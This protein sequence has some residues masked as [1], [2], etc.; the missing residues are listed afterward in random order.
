MDNLEE[1]LQGN[2]EAP[3]AEAVET[4]E[5]QPEV[6]E[7]PE[8][9]TEKARARDEK[10]RF[11]PKG[12][13]PAEPEG[14]SPAPAEPQLDHAALIG[15][16]RRRQEAEDRIRALEEQ[17]KTLQQTQQPTT[18]QDQGPPDRWEDPEGYDQWLVS[19][20]AERARAEARE[21][22]QVERIAMAA[23]EMKANHPDYAEKIGVFQQMVAVNPMLADEMRRSANP[24]RYAYDVAK[25]QIEI[26]QYGGLEGLINARVAAAQAQAPAPVAAAPI[27]N[28]LAD[29]QSARGG[30]NLT[31]AHVPTL[32]EILKR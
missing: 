6:A 22:F 20:A 9:E 15:E 32:D 14:A 16:R 1:F 8:T 12:E 3:E 13:T 26:S 29:E 5:A 18:Q 19:Q 23:E 31:G 17:F 4:V 11:A 27:P 24:A 21:A 28:T 2:N 25:T 7:Q 10:G 30:S